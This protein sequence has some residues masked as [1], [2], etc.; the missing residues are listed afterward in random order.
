MRPL[1][2]FLERLA[3]TREL[4]PPGHAQNDILISSRARKTRTITYHNPRTYLSFFFSTFYIHVWEVDNFSPLQKISSEIKGNEARVIFLEI[5]RTWLGETRSAC[6]E[7]WKKSFIP[8][9]SRKVDLQE[10]RNKYLANILL[11]RAPFIW[12]AS[13]GSLVLAQLAQKP[14]FLRLIFFIHASDSPKTNNEG[15]L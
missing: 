5:S 13:L 4:L 11:L 15:C 6:E 2:F 7:R 14:T 10:R 8:T 3:G 12:L 9:I 1:F